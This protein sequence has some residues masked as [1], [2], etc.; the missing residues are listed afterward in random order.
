[1]ADTNHFTPITNYLNSKLENIHALSNDYKTSLK[2]TK[3]LFAYTEELHHTMKQITEL[4]KKY[5][6]TINE[7]E[8][9]QLRKEQDDIMRKFKDMKRE[10]ESNEYMTPNNS[11]YTQHKD[12]HI[13]N[14]NDVVEGNA[15]DDNKTTND[16]DETTDDETTDNEGETT[17]NEGETTDDDGDTTDSDTENN[18]KNKTSKK[19]TNHS[20]TNDKEE[21]E[22]DLDNADKQDKQ[23]HTNETTPVNAWSSQTNDNVTADIKSLSS[24]SLPDTSDT[25]SQTQIDKKHQIQ[26]TL[27]S[28]SAQNP[29]NLL[30]K[31]SNSEPNETARENLSSSRLSR[32]DSI[33]DTDSSRQATLPKDASVSSTRKDKIQLSSNKNAS[34]DHV[35]N[36]SAKDITLLTPS[37]LTAQDALRKQKTRFSKKNNTDMRQSTTTTQTPKANKPNQAN[38]TPEQITLLSLP[39]HMSNAQKRRGKIAPKM[40]QA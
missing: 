15:E 16:D 30:S 37:V 35:D 17:D 24:Y 27:K 4:P 12:E 40:I 14:E 6:D 38:M 22:D 10:I 5:K 32:L 18:T 23:E 19:N 28:D 21:Q 1:M 13:M 3:Q 11:I 36:N 25:S 9:L 7:K 33:F 39:S 29:S 20:S 8:R 31:L 34:A 2:Q 26:D